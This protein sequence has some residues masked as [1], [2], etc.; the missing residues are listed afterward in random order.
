MPPRAGLLVAPS[1]GR[2]RGAQRKHRHKRDDEGADADDGARAAEPHDTRMASGDPER[3]GPP[4]SSFA[5]ASPSG[6]YERPADLRPVTSPTARSYA[7]RERDSEQHTEHTPRSPLRS[8]CG[9]NEE[10]PFAL[11]S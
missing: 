2:L 8:A 3:H 4:G 1:A 9:R 10:A 6:C 7:Y 5:A 11:N